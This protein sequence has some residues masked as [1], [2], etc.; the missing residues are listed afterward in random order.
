MRPDQHSGAPWKRTASSLR[1][2]LERTLDV[3]V[4]VVGAGIVGMTAAA[5][6]HRSGARVA[7]LEARRVAAA[8]SGNNTAKVTS[9]QGLAYTTIAKKRPGAGATYARAND[10]GIGLIAE[11]ASEHAIEC[12]LQRLPN[13]TFADEPGGESDLEREAEEARGAGLGVVLDDAAPLPFETYGAVRLDDQ[14]QFDPV[15]FL[16]GLAAHL[17]Q[18]PDQIL[19]E[20]SRVMSIDGTTLTTK[21]GAVNAEQVILAT[22]MPTL[23]HVGLFA[24]AEPKASFAIAARIPGEL[25]AGMFMDHSESYSIRSIPEIEGGLLLVGGQ[26][27]RIGQGDASASIAALERYARER[28]DATSIEYRW[29]AHD[30]VTEDRLPFV[31]SVTPRGDR[32][33]TVTGLNKWGLAL[34]AASAEMLVARV[35]TGERSWPEEFDSRRLPRPRGLPALAKHGAETAIHLAGDRLKRAN[36]DELEP[37]EGAVVGDGL[38]QVA[39]YRDDAGD[40]HRVSARCT[41]LG[42]IVA[43]NSA[44][45]TWDCPC[46]GS[47]FDTDGEV[48]EGPA[49]EPL[50]RVGER[51]S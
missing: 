47:R 30:F 23:D 26:G 40:L 34:G 27:H 49:T 44:T 3:D 12:G 42:C 45:K 32:V 41:H 6:L 31:G 29:D 43:F 50:S 14:I 36:E 33:M 22:H 39:A 48:L 35:S 7:V 28:F 46:H 4:A 13:F 37:G 8:S 25:P 10:R 51:R 15:A 21:D 19:F 18:A 9:L 2:P 20:G 38:S 17:D 24:R 16:E 5:L 1:A 11:L